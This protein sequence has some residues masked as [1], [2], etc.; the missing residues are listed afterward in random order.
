M[1]R[2]E[3]ILLLAGCLLVLA[4]LHTR[5]AF[6]PDLLPIGTINSE[7]PGTTEDLELPAAGDGQEENVEAGDTEGKEEAQDPGDTAGTA[8]GMDGKTAEKSEQVT[9]KAE[10]SGQ[11]RELDRKSVV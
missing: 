5:A 10:E 2:K 4:P 8:D 1:K 7:I 11:D 9:D 3:I 6:L